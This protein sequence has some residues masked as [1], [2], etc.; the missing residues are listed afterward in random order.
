MIFIVDARLSDG[1]KAEILKQV[2]ELACKNG[3][4]VLNS[5]VWIERQRI[6]FQ[7][8]K[9]WEGTYYLLNL[10]M[11]RDDIQRLRRELLINER[12]LRFLLVN[13]DELQAVA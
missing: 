13:A 3:G 4:K 10:E 7:L 12:V 11:K 8:K 9:A 6:A 2:V 5:S 1:E